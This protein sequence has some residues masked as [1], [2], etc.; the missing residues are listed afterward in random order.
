MTAQISSP[1]ILALSSDPHSAVYGSAKKLCNCD[2]GETP[3]LHFFWSHV[4]PSRV[5]DHAE[6]KIVN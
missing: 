2:N 6:K 1:D 4:D 3:S 5:G